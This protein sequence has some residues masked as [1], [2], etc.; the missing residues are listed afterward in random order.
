MVGAMEYVRS[1]L[2]PA[3][4][5]PYSQAVKAGCF[6]FISGQIPLD[7]QTGSMIEGDFKAKVRRAMDNVKAIV[8]AAGGT[9][10]K[11]VKVTV[12]LKDVSLFKEFNE[13]YASYFSSAR[14]ARSTVE[15][16]SLPRGAEIE[17]EAIAYLCEE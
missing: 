8:E 2:A 14:P 5:G 13:V 6:L 4:V 10:D 9:M 16:S 15:V 1:P 11:I 3:P 12:F 17:V 7:P